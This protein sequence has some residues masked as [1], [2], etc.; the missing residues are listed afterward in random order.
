MLE[1]VGGEHGV[2]H[3]DG[4]AS[5]D[6]VG[7]L[8]RPA[9]ALDGGRPQVMNLKDLLQAFIAFREEVIT[10]RTKFL[11]NKARERAHVLVGLA[12]AVANIDEVISLIRRAR[13]AAEAREG[14]MGRDWPA[15]DMAPLIELIADPRHKLQPDGTYRL[16][17][18]QARAILELRLARLTALG[19]DEIAD[20]LNKL[21]AEIADGFIYGRGACDMKGSVAAFAAAAMKPA[22][23][24]SIVNA[25]SID[26]AQKLLDWAISDEAMGLYAANFAIVAVPSQSQ[27][28]PN[29]CGA[30]STS[31]SRSRT[32][33]RART[34]SA[35]SPASSTA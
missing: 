23:G 14:L 3:R 35:N 33:R 19:R 8:R 18:E 32:I 20:E 10:R 34:R 30:A 1:H 25:D 12:I 22:T 17:E 13:D 4:R 15:K 21:A 5:A 29:V 9:L 28:L 7:E 2:E 26:A 6:G 31:A 11:L 27:P 24:Y 16:S